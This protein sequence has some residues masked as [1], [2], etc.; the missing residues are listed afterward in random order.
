MGRK[1]F[2]GP[3]G[4]RFVPETVIPALDELD[5]LRRSVLTSVE[6]RQ[7]YDQLLRTWAGRPT[8]LHEAQ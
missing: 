4:G 1:G 7:R 8:P 5:A 3:F 6:F 2:F